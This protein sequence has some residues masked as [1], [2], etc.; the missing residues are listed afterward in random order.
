VTVIGTGACISI[1]TPGEDR[2]TITEP[3]AASQV[4]HVD[5]ISVE[6]LI[7]G[8]EDGSSTHSGQRVTHGAYDDAGMTTSKR[9]AHRF[10]GTGFA[11]LRSI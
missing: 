5:A 6:H 4:Q 7:N 1:E 10:R 11:A 3:A 8:A 2:A 9:L